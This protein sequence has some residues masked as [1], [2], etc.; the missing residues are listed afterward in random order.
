LDI[1]NNYVYRSTS[2]LA[3]WA[4]LFFIADAF[5]SAMAAFSTAGVIQ[6]IDEARFGAWIPVERLEAADS[7]QFLL[8]ALQM[9]FGVLAG[10]LVLVWLYMANRNAHAL[11]PEGMKYTPAWSVGWFFIPIACL[12]LPYLV[13]R[14][15]WKASSPSADG[16]WRRNSVSPVLG[17]WWG[18]TVFHGCVHYEPIKILLGHWDLMGHMKWP[19]WEDGR[20]LEL[21][22]D[23]ITS[24]QENYWGFLAWSVLSVCGSVL[25][26]V[27]VVSITQM[28]ERKRAALAE[29]EALEASN[30]E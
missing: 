21:G 23:W 24:L 12:F 7:R 14:E 18:V 8:A 19:W 3:L 5:V 10:V 2:R 17:L 26:I 6:L 4:S 22:R 11:G 13:M 25:S 20:F 29:I 16:Q 1:G 27:V 9:G 28:Q 30:A 15:I